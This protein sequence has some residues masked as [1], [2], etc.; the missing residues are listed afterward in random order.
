MSS[1]RGVWK[2]ISSFFPPGE[3]C[4]EHPEA[5]KDA[6][7]Y[8][9]QLRALCHLSQPASDNRSGVSRCHQKEPKTWR[10][11]AY[12]HTCPPPRHRRLVSKNAPPALL[13]FLSFFPFRFQEKDGSARG[14]QTS[15]AMAIRCERN[16]QPPPLIFPSISQSSRTSEVTRY[17]T[18]I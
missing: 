10:Q 12:W 4:E 14:R 13:F 9:C 1:P 16:D 17:L 5:P 3:L 15:Q 6:H 8:R 18:A 11:A 7:L 2:T